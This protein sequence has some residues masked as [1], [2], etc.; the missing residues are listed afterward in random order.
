M[1]PKSGG[2]SAGSAPEAIIDGICGP[3]GRSADKT[4]R[5]RGRSSRGGA[6]LVEAAVRVVPFKGWIQD[7]AFPYFAFHQLSLYRPLLRRLCIAKPFGESVDE[8]KTGYVFGIGARI[9][10]DDQTTDECPAST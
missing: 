1:E 6:H 3:Q 2:M 10:P 7:Q 8:D 9:K 5:G 4:I